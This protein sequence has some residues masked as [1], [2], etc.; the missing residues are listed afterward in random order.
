MTPSQARLVQTSFAT[1]APQAEEVATA[2]YDRLFALDPALRRRFP[3]DM[4]EPRRELMA[5][6]ALAVQALDRRAT[7]VP[8]LE[9]LGR[10]HAAYG[11]E[12]AHHGTVGAALLATL[13]SQLGTGFDTELEAAWAAYYA[14]V[15]TIMRA[16]AQQAILAAAA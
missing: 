3:G 15:S 10:W 2:F 13:A 1:L 5:M 11:V 12:D 4:A 16:A 8:A 6:L 14:L 9:A 7:R